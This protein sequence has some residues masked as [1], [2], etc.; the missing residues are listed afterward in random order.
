MRKRSITALAGMVTAASILAGCSLTD[1]TGGFTEPSSRDMF[2]YQVSQELKTSNAGSNVGVSTNAHLLSGRLYPAVFV[3][4]PSGQ[5]IPNTDVARTQVLPGRNRQVIYTIETDAKFSDGAHL[6]CS[7]FLLAYTAGTHPDLFGAHMPLMD[8]ID[9]LD[10]LPGAKEFTVVFKEGQGDRWREL[11]GP[12]TILPAHVIGQRLEMD[13]NTFVEALESEDPDQLTPIAEIWREGFNLDNFDPELQVS[14]GP[15]RIDSVGEDGEV[16]LARNEHFNGDSAAL[17]NLVVWPQSA[18]SAELVQAGALRVADVQTDSPEWL[19]LNAEG[20]P[21]TVESM[22]GELTESLR[23]ADSGTWSIAEN[24]QALSQCVDQAAVAEASSEIAGVE[25]PP[26]NVHV[27][28]HGDPVARQLGE[29]SKDHLETDIEA[30]RAA[31]GTE[32][33]IGYATPNERKAAMVEAI[34]DSCEPAGITVVDATESGKTLDDLASIDATQSDGE[35]GDG[36]IDAFLGAIDPMSE[37]NS[38]AV[39]LSNVRA[40]RAHESYFWKELPTLPLAAQP[41]TFVVDRN[42]SNV[43][44]YTGPTGIGWNMDRWQVTD[45]ES[46]SDPE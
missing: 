10:C 20:N 13:A 15:F 35:A 23:F 7:D 36:S 44:V 16:V 25:V 3:P 26:V 32:I 1:G 46:T 14:F 31:T 41:R 18:D 24:R 39:N 12:G 37:Y 38:A 5:M 27:V 11:F 22:V 40:L 9:H 29:R 30:A 2:G 17:E 42:V 43:A 21:Y 19:D 45:E 28:R 6:T 8:Q 34:K 33:R 4:G